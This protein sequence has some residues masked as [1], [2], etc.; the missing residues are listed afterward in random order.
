MQFRNGTLLSLI[1]MRLLFELKVK[2]NRHGKARGLTIKVVVQSRKLG[3][4]SGQFFLHE[5]GMEANVEINFLILRYIHFI[6]REN[7]GGGGKGVSSFPLGHFAL[8][9]PLE[10][11]FD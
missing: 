10:L 9:S 7:W 5:E 8:S 1:K 4:K 3:F 2:E 11:R 6:I